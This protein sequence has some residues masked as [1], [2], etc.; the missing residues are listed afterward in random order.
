MTASDRLQATRCAICEEFNN[1]DEVYGPTFSPEDLTPAVFSARRSPDR[2]HYRLVR[3][4]R[5]GLVRSD[6]TADGDTIATLYR[7]SSFNYAGEVENLRQTYGG[8]LR[9]VIELGGTCGTL[10]EI[11]CGNG[12]FLEE[13]LARGFEQVA[14][15]EPSSDAAAQASPR[16]RERIICDVMRPGL[17]PRE[18]VDVV[19]MFQVLD[20]MADPGA[21]LR[22]CFQMLRPGGFLLCLQ[23]NARAISTRFLGERSPIFDI[24]HTYLYDRRTLTVLLSKCGFIP[25]ECKPVWNRYSV[26]YLVH[27]LPLSARTRGGVRS[28]LSSLGLDRFALRAPLGNLYMIARKPS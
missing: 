5:C 7:R 18:T 6:P 14:G 26:G 11:G 4:R 3:C 22:E 1:A 20:H 28:A 24:E 25:V 23:H 13:A 10:T 12:F 19:A 17:F 27:L 8:Y 2:I 15:V 9:R 16:L 21:V